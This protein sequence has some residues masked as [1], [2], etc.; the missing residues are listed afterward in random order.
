MRIETTAPS[1]MRVI[2]VVIGLGVVGLPT[3]ELG[4]GVW[5]PNIASPFFLLIIL[6]ACTL[7]VSAI[8][9]GLFGWTDTWTIEPG[10]IEIERR[11]P[12]TMRRLVFLPSDV[13]AIEV[14]EHKAMEGENTYGV[15]LAAVS[16]ERY[17][18][19]RRLSTRE[20]AEELLAEI[21]HAFQA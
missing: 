8:M 15:V 10:R 19:P 2:V 11:N 13:G 4:R 18:A 7:G 6:G 21:R 20:F 17:D 9:G 3:W 14:V 12:F 5:P 1:W 16:G